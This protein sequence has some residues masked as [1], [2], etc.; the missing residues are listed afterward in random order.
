VLI[1]FDAGLSDLSHAVAVCIVT[2]LLPP[3]RVRT[4]LVPISFKRCTL[5]GVR[6]SNSSQNLHNDRTGRCC[7]PVAERHAETSRQG[8]RARVPAGTWKASRR[9]TAAISKG[10][11]AEGS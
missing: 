3:M 7:C 10:R 4:A 11:S 8:Y 6:S 1:Y 2:A 5:I 9:P